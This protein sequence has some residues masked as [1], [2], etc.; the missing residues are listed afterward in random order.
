M[1]DVKMSATIA[2]VP[3]KTDGSLPRKLLVCVTFHFDEG[4]LKYL[5]LI[6]SQFSKLGNNVIAY[7]I[8]N[9]AD[10]ASLGKIDQVLRRKGFDYDVLF[11][12]L[13]GHPYLL[14][15]CHFDV[16]RTKLRDDSIT[17]F[18]YLE[19]DILVTPANVEYWMIGREHLR[20]TNFI[21]SFIRYEVQDG[22]P[23]LLSTDIIKRIYFPTAPKIRVSDTHY[24]INS[25]YPYQG[26]YLLDRSLMIEHL[27]NMTS[28]LDYG[29]LG[30]REKAAQGI[31]FSNVPSGFHSRNLIG[32]DAWNNKM[33][34]NCLIHHTPNNYAN[35]PNTPHAKIPVND[36]IIGASF[37]R[38]VALKNKLSI[39]RPLA[40][41]ER[42]LSQGS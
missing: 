1:R 40:T 10:A 38:I 5:D 3:T 42:S 32:Y 17:H 26:M 16:I 39:G 6:S 30:I 25:K 27:S 7:I 28:F 15:W 2:S 13:L 33:D 24:Y 9:N 12:T 20:D 31:I 8:T 14:A 23:A 22:E 29:T 4:R 34:Q 19:D 11:P 21:P 36:L 41:E 35:N 37:S 18:L